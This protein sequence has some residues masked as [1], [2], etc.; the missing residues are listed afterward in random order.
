MKNPAGAEFD[1]FAVF[2]QYPYA[3][4]LLLEADA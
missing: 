3:A 1:L 4:A 2:K